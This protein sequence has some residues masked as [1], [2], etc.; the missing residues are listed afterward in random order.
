MGLTVDKI[1]YQIGTV[2]GQVW[3]YLDKH[4]SATA[5]KLKSELGISNGMLHLALG[6]LAR[7]DKIEIT[8][9]AH[10][11]RVSLKKTT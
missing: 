10:S 4:E 5:L 7:E 2:A 8:A 1:P 3:E 6:W 11:F 9:T